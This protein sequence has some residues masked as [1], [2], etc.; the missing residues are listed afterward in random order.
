MAVTRRSF[1]AL[2]LIGVL[3]RRLFALTREPHPEPRPGITAAKIPASADLTH[4]GVA[5]AF[6]QVR[7]IPHLVDGIRCHCGCAT[8]PDS[9]SLLSCF[10]GNNAMAQHCAICQGQGRLAFRLSQ[11]GKSLDQIRTA[12][13]EEFGDQ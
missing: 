5:R 2:A 11:E 10:E 13:D 8:N 9:Y 1:V 4:R 12:I 6:D 3:P 7:Q